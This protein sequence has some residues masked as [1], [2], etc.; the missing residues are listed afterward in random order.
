[1]RPLVYG[2]DLGYIF[3]ESLE[4]LLELG[5]ITMIEISTLGKTPE[6]LAKK[7]IQETVSGEHDSQKIKITTNIAAKTHFSLQDKQLSSQC[8]ER[9]EITAAKFLSQVGFFFI[10]GIVVFVLCGFIVRVEHFPC[11]SEHLVSLIVR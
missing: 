4:H 5:R 8:H 6:I 7:R 11:P 1:M 10:I 2:V 3:R 9:I